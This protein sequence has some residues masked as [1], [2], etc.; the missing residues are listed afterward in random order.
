MPE[1]ET[2]TQRIIEQ[3][4]KRMLEVFPDGFDLKEEDLRITNPGLEE[5]DFH[6]TRF[7]RTKPVMYEFDKDD[8]TYSVRIDDDFEDERYQEIAEFWKNEVFLLLESTFVYS[9]LKNHKA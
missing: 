4:R 5:P 3:N 1:T 9:W 7:S 2:D 6:Y 8:N